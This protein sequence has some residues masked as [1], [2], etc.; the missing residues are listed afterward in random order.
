MKIGLLQKPVVKSRVK[1]NQIW[2]IKGVMAILKPLFWNN[3][4][5]Y[6]NKNI[7]NENI[8]SV[9]RR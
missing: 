3:T 1:E 8:Y 2:M 6:T 4:N 5:T 7:D 9:S